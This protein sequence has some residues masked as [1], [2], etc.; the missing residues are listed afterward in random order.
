MNSIT[1]F[2]ELVHSETSTANLLLGSGSIFVQNA[3]EDFLSHSPKKHSLSDYNAV[4]YF[5]MFFVYKSIE[6]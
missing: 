6:K 1:P 2:K 5:S 4:Y 3:E